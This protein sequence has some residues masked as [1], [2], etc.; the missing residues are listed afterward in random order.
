MSRELFD[1]AVRRAGDLAGVFEYDGETGYFYLYDT[2]NKILDAIHILTGDSEMSA[3]DVEVRWDDNEFRV[4]L[5]LRGTQWAVFN[6]SS[7]EK[8][9]G[10]YRPDAKPQIPAVDI[11]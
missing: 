3:E 8:H 9:G 4:A 1:Q 7:G 5:F 2:G 6:V 11:F 10:N